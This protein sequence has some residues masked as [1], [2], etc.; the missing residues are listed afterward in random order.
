MGKKKRESIS[1][2]RTRANSPSKTA[3]IDCEFSCIYEKI[4]DAK[5]YRKFTRYAKIYKTSK[6]YCFL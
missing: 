2:Q 3:L 4:E 1:I 6:I 5:I